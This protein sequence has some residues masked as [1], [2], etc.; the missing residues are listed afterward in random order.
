M[1]TETPEQLADRQ[2]L[3]RWVV[4]LGAAKHQEPFIREHLVRPSSTSTP[5][6]LRCGPTLRNRGFIEADGTRL[7]CQLCLKSAYNSTPTGPVQP[8]AMPEREL[9]RQLRRV[10]AERGELVKAVEERALTIQGLEEYLEIARRD[11][12]SWEDWGNGWKAQAQAN[13]VERDKAWAELEI[14]KAKLRVLRESAAEHG[15]PLAR[16][17]TILQEVE[18]RYAADKER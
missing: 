13:Q 11:R 16:V 4:L 14:A 5:R 2:A 3:G 7:P 8:W 6:A 17:D 1:T 18:A 12:S 9:E 10:E 15:V